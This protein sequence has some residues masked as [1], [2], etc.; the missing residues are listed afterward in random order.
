MNNELNADAHR[1][2]DLGYQTEVAPTERDSELQR[3]RG[4]L[5]RQLA[6]QRKQSLYSVLG[7]Q[8]DSSD[9]MIADVIRRISSSGSPLDAETRYAVD[10]LG[11]P[12]ARES[13]DRRMLEQLKEPAATPNVVFFSEPSAAST[14]VT[15][16]KALALVALV[17]GMGYLG[18]GYTR[19]QSEREIRIKEVEQ[20]EA[21]ARRAAEI[22]ERAAENQKAAIDA[23]V[24]AQSRAE[25]E[26]ERIQLDARMRED[27]Q[28]IDMAYRQ[29][30]QTAQ[31]EQRRQQAETNRR[32]AEAAN[33]MRAVRQ[34][35]IQDAL[36]RGNV[37][38]AQRLRNLSY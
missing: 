5:R 37:N 33:A 15:S 2:V 17:L 26:R 10:A 12:V 30:Q 29:E 27:K 24:A 7:V 13:F 38:E 11:D 4:E 20:R 18:L 3:L 35:A 25:E 9:A 28:R 6:L 31:M 19:Q 36:A 21:A 16:S 1:S 34:Q 14:W 23:A 8:A 32:E 22:A